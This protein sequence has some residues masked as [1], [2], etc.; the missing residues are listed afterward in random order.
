M[1]ASKFRVSSS[2]PPSE[3]ESRT[4]TRIRKSLRSE[5]ERPHLRL[6][7]RRPEGRQHMGHIITIVLIRSRT[8]GP[9]AGMG[10]TAHPARNNHYGNALPAGRVSGPSHS[11]GPAELR[12]TMTRMISE[13]LRVSESLVS[14]RL[15]PYTR[16]AAAGPGWDRGKMSLRDWQAAVYG[17]S[18]T[19]RLSG[20]VRDHRAI[21]LF[22]LTLRPG[23]SG[24]PQP[25]DRAGDGRFRPPGHP[26]A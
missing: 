24:S 22:R 4:W 6:P 3:S 11:S 1:R 19:V 26:V 10:W 15:G 16:A 13:P 5:K 21:G 7:P 2:P 8:S 23:G 17:L 20:K 9:Y 18:G 25:S 12:R 14:R